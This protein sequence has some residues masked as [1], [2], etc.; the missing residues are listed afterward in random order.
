ME[1][2]DTFL[3]R[4][5][6]IFS[7]QE[8]RLR[9]LT[10]RRSCYIPKWVILF[11]FIADYCIPGQVISAVKCVTL[12]RAFT[13]SVGILAENKPIFHRPNPLLPMLNQKEIGDSC[14]CLAKVIYYYHELVKVEVY[15]NRKFGNSGF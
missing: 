5:E 15:L 4:I 8:I 7:S 10:L 11:W 6:S 2:F 14:V 1:R 13:L 12:F 3:S 9:K